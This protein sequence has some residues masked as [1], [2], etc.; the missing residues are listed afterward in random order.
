M[1]GN[2]I[3]LHGVVHTSELSRRMM[4]QEDTSLWDEMWVPW[5]CIL[6]DRVTSVKVCSIDYSRCFIAKDTK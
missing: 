5:G 6:T 3:K 4:E 2:H 1:F